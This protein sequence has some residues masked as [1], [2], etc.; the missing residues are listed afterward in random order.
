LDVLRVAGAGRAKIIAIC[1]DD[2]KAADKAVETI[3]SEFPLAK[4]LVRSYDRGHSL[5]L[6]AAGVDY[7]IRETLE[8]AMRFGEAALIALGVPQEEAAE[9]AGDVR[10]R[11]AE[12]FKA[13][14]AEGIYGGRDLIRTGPTPTPLSQPKRHA[15]PLSPETAAVADDG[16]AGA[17]N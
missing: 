10:K 9:I 2:R 17:E 8:S 14:M 5:S 12:R 3:K 15:Q 6:I 1:I 11:D 7:E 4:L 16:K 13:Q